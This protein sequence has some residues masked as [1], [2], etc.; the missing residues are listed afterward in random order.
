MDLFMIR[1]KRKEMMKFWRCDV[2]WCMSIEWLERRG[3]WCL[4]SFYLNGINFFLCPNSF[5]FVP[6]KKELFS[7]LLKNSSHKQSSHFRY[8]NLQQNRWVLTFNSKS[9]IWANSL[10]K[11]PIRVDSAMPSTFMGFHGKYWQY[12]ENLLIHRLGENISATFCNAM[13]TMK[14]IK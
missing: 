14:V 12:P 8:F 1:D 4:F 3:G 9:K 10:K 7:H 11:D 5:F 2:M 13:P 6:K